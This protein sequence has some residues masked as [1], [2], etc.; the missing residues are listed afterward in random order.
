MRTLTRETYYCDYCNKMYISKYFCG[1]HEHNCS[2]NPANF[3]DCFSCRGCKKTIGTV[4]ETKD[5]LKEPFE[6]N[7]FYCSFIDM[8]LTPPKAENKGNMYTMD[9]EN[10]FMPKHCKAKEEKT[11][12]DYFD[13][14]MKP[15]DKNKGSYFK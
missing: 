10:V 9:K 5:G 1:K 15:Y 2:K 6:T 13:D 14:L 8:Y 11:A 4:T 3:R 7:V 12:E